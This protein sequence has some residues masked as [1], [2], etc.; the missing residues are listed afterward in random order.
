MKIGHVIKVF[1]YK[2]DYNALNN[3]EISINRI[4]DK[5]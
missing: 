4:R 1:L 2:V 3:R 5:T